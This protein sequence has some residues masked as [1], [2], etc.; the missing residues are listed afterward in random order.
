MS[1]NPPKFRTVRV[2]FMDHLVE[3]KVPREFAKKARKKG[4]IV[5]HPITGHLSL[6]EFSS[7][8]IYWFKHDFVYIFLADD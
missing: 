3:Y 5:K 6:A 1:S 7:I 2:L 8:M 4:L